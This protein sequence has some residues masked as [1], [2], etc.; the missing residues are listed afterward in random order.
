MHSKNIVEMG[1]GSAR[2]CSFRYHLH[3]LARLHK[4]LPIRLILFTSVAQF[5][6]LSRPVPC[7]SSGILSFPPPMRAH[8][9]SIDLASSTPDISSN[10][11]ISP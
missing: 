4:S 3:P 9:M 11:H 6:S 1:N 8:D 2:I 7:T 5:S 10:C